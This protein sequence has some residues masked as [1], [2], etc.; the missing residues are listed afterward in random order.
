MIEQDARTLSVI[1]KESDLGTETMPHGEIKEFADGAVFTLDRPSKLN[2]ITMAMLD[3][4]ERC[5]DTQLRR[6]ARLLV[7]VGR[8]DKAFS[9]GTD[10]QELQQLSHD[11]QVEKCN[12]ARDLFMRLSRS[13]V[14]T[15]AAINGLAFGGGLELA[16]SCTLRIASPS[17]TFSL[18]EIKLG[19]LPAYAGTQMLPTI[20]GRARALEMMLTGR[21]LSAQEALSIGLIHR[22]SDT[23]EPIEETAIRFGQD[24][25]RNNAEAVRAIRECVDASASGGLYASGL[26][27]EEDHVRTVF[28]SAEARQGIDRFMARRAEGKT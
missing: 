12:R 5:L 3:D 19:L 13:Q 14:V 24:V 4:L 23:D 9:A 25:V 2:A 21:V 6:G 26:K 16:M 1:G 7:L 20:V 18:P 28:A 8:G 10:V 17:A 11:H 27:T 22:L 15:V